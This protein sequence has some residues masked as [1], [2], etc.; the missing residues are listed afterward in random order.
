MIVFTVFVVNDAIVVIVVISRVSV[1]V[2]TADRQL[3][4][5]DVIT[6]RCSVHVAA[7]RT[8]SHQLLHFAATILKP[9]L[10]LHNTRHHSVTT[11]DILSSASA[12]NVKTD[13]MILDITRYDGAEHDKSSA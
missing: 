12:V 9:D 10:H 2:S 11:D 6:S 5:L 13:L 7:A 1:T 4:S 3:I 8:V